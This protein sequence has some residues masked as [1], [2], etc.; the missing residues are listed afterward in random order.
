VRDVLCHRCGRRDL[1][2]PRLAAVTIADIARHHGFRSA[3]VFT[4]AFTRRYRAGPRA[5][6]REQLR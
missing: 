4:R 1:A 2:D 6:R 5:F 3:A